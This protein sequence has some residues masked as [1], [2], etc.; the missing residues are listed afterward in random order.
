MPNVPPPVTAEESN[1]CRFA[2]NN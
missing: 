1:I 2:A